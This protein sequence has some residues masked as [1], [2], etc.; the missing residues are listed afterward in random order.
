MGAEPYEQRCRK[1]AVS[2]LK[3]HADYLAYDMVPHT[4][5][6]AA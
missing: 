1:Q 6:V 3:V 5:A 4:P 2:N